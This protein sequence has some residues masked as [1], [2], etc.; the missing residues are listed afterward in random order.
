MI[1]VPGTGPDRATAEEADTCR[2]R[3]TTIARLRRL[4][5]INALDEVQEAVDRLAAEKRPAG[6]PVVRDFV[7]VSRSRGRK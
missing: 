1:A 7:L 3:Q 6:W 5:M 2:T 4:K